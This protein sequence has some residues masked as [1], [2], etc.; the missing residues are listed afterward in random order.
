MGE[1]AMVET[2]LTNELIEAGANLVRKLDAQSLAPDAAFWFYF[3]D[4]QAWK[5]VLVEVKMGQVGPRKI[6]REVQKTLA[7]APEL[8]GL[9]LDDV[10]IAKPDTPI[11]ALLRTAVH[12]GPGI[13]GIRFRNHVI[14]GTLIDDAFIYRLN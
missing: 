13:T 12:T 10:S 5:L 3:P 1:K 6:Y 14:G 2:N 11:I 8:G 4:T 9:T 7:D